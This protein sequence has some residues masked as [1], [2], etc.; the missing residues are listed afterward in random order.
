MTHLAVGSYALKTHLSRALLL[1]QYVQTTVEEYTDRI[2]LAIAT[3]HQQNPNKL[4][5]PWAY[6]TLCIC[7]RIFDTA[8]KKRIDSRISNQGIETRG[9][10]KFRFLSAVRPI[11]GLD[12]MIFKNLI[13]QG[14]R[15]ILILIFSLD[16]SLISSL[17]LDH[18]QL[19]C[20]MPQN[21]CIVYRVQ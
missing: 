19:R 11:A 5:L 10:T 15:L 13:I 3:S 6:S 2:S 17:V 9:Y 1:A 21:Y 14:L 4:P 18:C 12:F 8:V 7:N 16:L 20:S